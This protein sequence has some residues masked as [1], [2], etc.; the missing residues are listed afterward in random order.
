MTPIILYRMSVFKIARNSVVVI[1]FTF[2]YTISTFEHYGILY[3]LSPTVWYIVI[4]FAG[5][6][7]GYFFSFCVCVWGGNFGFLK[8]WFSLYNWN[9]IP[10]GRWISKDSNPTMGYPA[11]VS[12]GLTHLCSS[13]MNMSWIKYKNREKNGK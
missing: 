3:W 11:L 4:K 10:L 12:M 6:R 8:K 1:G 7:W 5:G 2:I 13:N 9:S